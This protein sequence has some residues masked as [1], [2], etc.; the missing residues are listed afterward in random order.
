MENNIKAG[1]NMSKKVIKDKKGDSLRIKCL[2]SYVW[3]F[4]CIIAAGALMGIKVGAAKGFLLFLASVPIAF[5]CAF[6][7][8]IYLDFAEN[9]R[10]IKTELIKLNENK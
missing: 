8:I 6:A 4:L 3:V 2:R 10:D 7:M 1:G 5:L 9:I